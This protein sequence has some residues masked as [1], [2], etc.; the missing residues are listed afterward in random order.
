MHHEYLL[1]LHKHMYMYKSQSLRKANCNLIL[2]VLLWPRMGRPVPVYIC[3]IHSILWNALVEFDQPD[4]VLLYGHRIPDT[5]RWSP[6]QPARRRQRCSGYR[7]LAVT[8]PIST[9]NDMFVLTVISN[10]NMY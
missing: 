1:I 3:D 8:M 5:I 7:T 2:S 10:H 9:V 6:N 4:K